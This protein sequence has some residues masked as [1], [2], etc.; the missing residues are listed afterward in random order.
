[1]G[2]GDWI[3]GTPL[4]RLQED[5]APSAPAPDPIEAITETTAQAT[6]AATEFVSWIGSF[7]LTSLISL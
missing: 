4:R 2:F 6:E 3:W 5:S 1:M 7:E